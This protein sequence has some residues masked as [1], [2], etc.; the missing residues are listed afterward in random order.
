MWFGLCAAWFFFVW[1]R[2]GDARKR[3][4]VYGV[5]YH[6]EKVARLITRELHAEGQP[7][8][9]KERLYELQE[10]VVRLLHTQR[11]LTHGRTWLDG[12]NTIAREAS[13]QE[14]TAEVLTEPE[15]AT[16]PA[17]ERETVQ[18]LVAYFLQ[19]AEHAKHMSPVARWWIGSAQI[20][21]MQTYGAR[22]T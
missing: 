10:Q 16:I 19:R 11:W 22:A 12:R 2:I 7:I 4:L 1:L 17:P 13:L 3:V 8:V 20:G 18:L 9:T 5:W 6:Q 15:F 21:K 14:I